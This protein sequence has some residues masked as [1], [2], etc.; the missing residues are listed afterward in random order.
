MQVC[1]AAVLPCCSSAVVS[2]PASLYAL[3]QHCVLCLRSQGILCPACTQLHLHSILCAACSRLSPHSV[4]CPACSHLHLHSMLC[5]ACRGTSGPAGPAAPPTQVQSDEWADSIQPGGCHGAPAVSAPA[6]R[7]GSKLRGHPELG[8]QRCECS[9]SNRHGRRTVTQ[10]S[11]QLSACCT[12]KG[13]GAPAEA[14]GSR[15]PLLSS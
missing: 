14:C 2:C 5:P 6:Q 4:L 13:T 15:L 3:S 12:C 7:Q 10:G 1:H 9:A 8:G 11:A